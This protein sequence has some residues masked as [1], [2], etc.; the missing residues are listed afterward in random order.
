MIAAQLRDE[1][2]RQSALD[3]YAVLDTAPDARF[4]AI[5]ALVRAVFEVPIALVSLVDRERQWFKSCDGLE[6]SETPRVWSLCTH[7]I[8]QH[9]PLTVSDTHADPRFRDSPL[10]VGPPHIRSYAG[11]PLTTPD[12]YNVGSLCA[13]DT[14]PREFTESQIEM[15]RDF[16]R[17]VIA[18]LELRQIAQ[19]DFLT[20]ALSRRGFVSRLDAAI[21]HRFVA[22]AALVTFDIDHFKPINDRFG[23]PTGDEVLKQI[24]RA[25]AESLRSGDSFGRM[26]GEEFALLLPDTDVTAALAAAERCRRA[27]A[28]LSIDVGEVLKV[29]ASF[30]IAP[31][32]DAVADTD[33]WLCH[34]D[35]ALYAAKA[36]GRNRS[37][38]SRP[39][40]VAA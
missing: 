17:I 2:G 23:H 30:G 5:T 37:R 15:L 31:L 10:V 22:P 27:I 34:A 24:A 20:G 25:C 12:G 6:A 16:G 33:D 7:T 36:G 29:T 28:A 18:E 40:A 9:T 1:N 32:T 8:R 26:G 14:V 4:D 38:L 11:V 39:L 35:A 21:E 3:R 19:S 13:I